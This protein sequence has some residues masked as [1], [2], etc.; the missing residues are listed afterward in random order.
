MENDNRDNIPVK[1]S[2][3]YDA[4]AFI[5]TNRDTMKGHI[6]NLKK[7]FEEHGN[8]TKVQPIVVNEN[9]EV[10]DGQNR[11][12]AAKELHEPVYY[13]VV[14]GLTIHDARS[15]NIL[16][17]KWEVLDYAK[18]YAVSGNQHYQVYLQIR[19]EYGFSHKVLLLYLS[20]NA[21]HGPIYKQFRE[22]DFQVYDI[23]QSRNLL[24]K[25]SEVWQLLPFR[26]YG[27]AEALLR[28][29]K[30]EGYDQKRMIQRLI[31]NVDKLRP[32]VAA[33]DN[34][35][36]LEDLYN[37]GLRDHNRVRFF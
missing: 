17:N 33:K 32:F 31:V 25:L 19:E 27:M 11:L 1:V 2:S 22:G 15:M 30:A 20:G 6:N 37:T 29:F 35:R 8:L 3:N 7:A 4:F 36:Q 21:N 13:R 34:I 16:H 5:E 9:L 24:D 26:N 23:A 18:S 10:I 12:I 28:A 14:P